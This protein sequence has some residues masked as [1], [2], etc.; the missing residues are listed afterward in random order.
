MGLIQSIP[1]QQD[2]EKEGTIKRFYFDLETS[3]LNPVRNGI[4]QMALIL[5]I[6]DVIKE[7]HTFFIK[8]FKDDVIDPEAT[9]IHGLDPTDGRFEE[10]EIVFKRLVAILDKYIDKYDTKDKAFMVGYNCQSFDKQFLY[11]WFVKNG[12]KFMF[13]YF[14]PE[15][16]DVFVLMGYAAQK[17][18]H[19]LGDGKLVTY[20]K[21]V[22]IDVDES[23][24]HD[25]MFDTNL[26]Y[27]LFK[28]YSKEYPV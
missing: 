5:E 15:T 27:K 16:L 12:N 14:Y 13:S 2:R 6:N 23:K 8:P 26:T 25:A 4:L 9:A 21:S 22:G 24:L 17:Q 28:L 7:K 11:E 20:A 3:G 10:P 18:R 1:E 19:L